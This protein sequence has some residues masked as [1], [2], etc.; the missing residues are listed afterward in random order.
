MPNPFAASMKILESCQRGGASVRFLSEFVRMIS[1][2]R[3]SLQLS[4][5][6]R[7]LR[8]HFDLLSFWEPR[9]YLACQRAGV[10]PQFKTWDGDGAWSHSPGR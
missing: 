9:R 1:S 6:K 10:T 3:Q 5:R 7:F 4:I 2:R 8:K